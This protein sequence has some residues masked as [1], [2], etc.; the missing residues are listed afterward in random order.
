M[1]K[2]LVTKAQGASAG[3]TSAGS[4]GLGAVILGRHLIDSYEPTAMEWGVV[5]L[6]VTA[7][8]HLIGRILRKHNIID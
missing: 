5:G 6:T 8:L 4:L 2:Q 1:T 7:G 3:I